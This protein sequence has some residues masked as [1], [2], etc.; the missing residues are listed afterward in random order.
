[1]GSQLRGEFLDFTVVAEA[2]DGY[3]AV[4]ALAELDPAFREPSVLL[5]WKKDGKPLDDLEGPYR[6]LSTADKR[7]ARSVKMLTRLRLVRAAKQR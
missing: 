1:V 3:K 2:R 6:L 4:F 7:G 5:V